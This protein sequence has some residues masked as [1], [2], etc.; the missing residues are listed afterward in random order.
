[1]SKGEGLEVCAVCLLSQI[2]KAD[3]LI[4][5]PDNAL[6]ECRQRQLTVYLCDICDRL[7]QSTQHPFLV[8]RWQTNKSSE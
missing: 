8:K 1:M 7:I 6:S 2:I 3:L 5:L 4:Q